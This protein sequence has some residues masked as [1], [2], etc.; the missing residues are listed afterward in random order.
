[1]YFL[2]NLLLDSQNILKSEIRELYNLTTFFCVGFMLKADLCVAVLGVLG[3]VNF[4]DLSPETLDSS[5][6]YNILFP[7][8]FK[9]SLQYIVSR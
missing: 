3:V 2:N 7:S 4:G 6:V 9:S 1:M 8:R 5:L